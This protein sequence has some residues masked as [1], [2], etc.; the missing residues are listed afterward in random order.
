M[1]CR[2]KVGIVVDHPT[3]DLFGAVLL[4]HTLALRGLRVSLIP[5]YHQ[6]IDAP[7][8]D[9]DLIVLNYARPVN[10]AFAQRCHESGTRVA[11]LDSEGGLL[12]PWGPNS[13]RGIAE[14]IRASGFGEA[15][16][17]Y[18]CW[19]EA[20]AEALR[21]HSGMAADSVAVTGC[22]R[23]DF[24]SEPWNRALPRPGERYIL[25]NTNFPMINSRFARD[26]LE[27]RSSLKTLG[28]SDDIIEQALVEG[29][30]VRAAMTDAVGALAAQFPE[31]NFLVRPHPFERH[32]YY[33][34][35]FAGLANVA[36]SHRGPVLEAIGGA[37]AVLQVNCTT[38]VEAVICGVLPIGLD[39]ANQ[40]LLRD[41][42]ALATRVS[43][44]AA[45]YA[46]LAQIVANIEGETRA[47]DFERMRRE[48]IR[49]HFHLVDGRAHERA[50]E[51]LLLL[52][53]GES[54]SASGRRPMARRGG[55]A[56][57]NAFAG[58]A[59][60]IGSRLAGKL[61]AAVQAKR[62]GKLFAAKDVEAM[63]GRLEEIT[64]SPAA[65]VRHAR[66]RW[67]AP[68]ASVL[69]E[70]PATASGPPA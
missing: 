22:P 9:L 44:N 16:C 38:A 46:D 29:R 63:L 43:R 65:S 2:K 49:P 23:F 3:R 13:P 67:G 21:S 50:A 36:V 11:V 18:L 56:A 54:G 70:P 8:L 32:S 37:E 30:A 51:R 20:M 27:D 15:L 61:R 68:L 28:F 69:I 60:L 1:L 47:F 35:C 53:E 7:Y 40:P 17:A 4:A 62:R 14:Y 31:K 52:L 33:H 39:Y 48:Y 34:Q 10:L 5:F 57:Q 26:G 6:Q 25:V 19:G 66:N 64:G 41:V 24:A 58:L 12:A 55:T 45:D 59:A 42:S